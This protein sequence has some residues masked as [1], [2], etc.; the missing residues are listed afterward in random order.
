[1]VRAFVPELCLSLIL[2]VLHFYLFLIMIENEESNPVLTTARMTGLHNIFHTDLP[3]TNRRTDLFNRCF[4]VKL[5][6]PTL[7]QVL[8]DGFRNRFYSSSQGPLGPRLL[9]GSLSQTAN[10]D[11]RLRAWKFQ[12][13]HKEIVYYF[14]LKK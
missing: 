12:N 9:H 10:G 6:S 11:R 5:H 14:V 8:G 1:M 7:L 4:S 13:I 2:T 3:S